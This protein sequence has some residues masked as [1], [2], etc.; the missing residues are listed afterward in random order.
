MRYPEFYVEL[1]YINSDYE[2]LGTAG[3][4]YTAR[5]SWKNKLFSRALK[6][7]GKCTQI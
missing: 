2:Q 4:Q 1:F 5:G 3:V 7:N 6:E